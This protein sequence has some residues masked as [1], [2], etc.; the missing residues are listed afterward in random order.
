MNK[1]PLLNAWNFNSFLSIHRIQTF[2]TVR[3]E[4]FI[5]QDVIG[6]SRSRQST[7]IIATFVLVIFDFL[8]FRTPEILIFALFVCFELTAAVVVAHLHFFIYSGTL[9]VH[10][11]SSTKGVCKVTYT[12]IDEYKFSKPDTNPTPMKFRCSAL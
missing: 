2:L 11:V 12:L 8:S 1:L 6:P 4:K 3:V 7:I 9:T 10:G 5:F